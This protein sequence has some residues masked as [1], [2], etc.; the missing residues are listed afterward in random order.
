MQR[1]KRLHSLFILIGLVLIV[2]PLLL[3]VRHTKVGMEGSQLSR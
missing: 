2:K 3:Q 1:D